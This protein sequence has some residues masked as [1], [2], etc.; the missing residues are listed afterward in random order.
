MGLS[1]WEAS[2]SQLF[3]LV[4]GA[5]RYVFYVMPLIAVIVLLDGIAERVLTDA[6]GFILVDW[7]SLFAND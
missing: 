5:N 6:I 7:V 1:P 4:T 3:A 2:D